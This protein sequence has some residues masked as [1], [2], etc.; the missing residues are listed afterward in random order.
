MRVSEPPEQLV[1]MKFY[2]YIIP[3][4]ARYSGTF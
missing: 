3:L 4:E 1:F 2:M